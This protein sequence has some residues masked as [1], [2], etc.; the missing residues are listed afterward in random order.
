LG[1]LRGFVRKIFPTQK[2]QAGA[3]KG[4]NEEAPAYRHPG[5]CYR[6]GGRSNKNLNEN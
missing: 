3:S 2:K 4:E 6:G 5:F 1:V